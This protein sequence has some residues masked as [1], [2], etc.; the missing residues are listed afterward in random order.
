M[1]DVVYISEP[2]VAPRTRENSVSLT[3]EGD[4]ALIDAV[5]PIA[6]AQKFLELCKEAEKPQKPPKA[7]WLVPSVAAALLVGW[8][9][10]SPM[11][12]EPASAGHKEHVVPVTFQSAL[13]PVKISIV[14]GHLCRSHRGLRVEP[15]TSRLLRC[16]GLDK[17][18]LG[19]MPG[20]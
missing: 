8:L 12:P 20:R 1:G 17:T 10:P 2:L 19:L 14:A 18:M 6:V 9:A 15:N 7:K 16:D 4:K 11:T 5:V 13:Q 3:C